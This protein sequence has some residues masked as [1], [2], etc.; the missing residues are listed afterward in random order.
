M[1]DVE[2]TKHSRKLHRDRQKTYIKKDT[3]VVCDRVEKSRVDKRYTSSDKK[4]DFIK[5]LK[6]LDAYKG[7]NI[8]RCLSQMDAW[9]MIHPGR[10]KNAK[11]II[12]WLN[13][14]LEKNPAISVPKA[15]PNNGKDKEQLEKW[16]KEAAP[17]PKEC[18]EQL[19]K[20][21]IRSGV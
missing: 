9:L 1:E 18:R 16:K 6:T 8:D 17:M 14:E 4:E 19:T 12:N 2:K 3:Q 7:L 20:F 13:K 11:F 10:Q 21:G 15:A 5:K